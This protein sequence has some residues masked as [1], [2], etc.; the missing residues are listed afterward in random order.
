M[1][2]A[3]SEH[4]SF[5]YLPVSLKIKGQKGAQW[6]SYIGVLL[7]KF[8]VDMLQVKMKFRLNFF[9]LDWFFVS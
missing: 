9:N 5:E 4:L 8:L 2:R 3:V 1:Y 7:G 6:K